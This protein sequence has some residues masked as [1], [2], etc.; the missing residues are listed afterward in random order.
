MN[1]EL[2]VDETSEITENGSIKLYV[3]VPYLY[4]LDD[5]QHIVYSLR[6]DFISILEMWV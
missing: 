5:G 3:K 4:Q 1:D 2:V 6:R